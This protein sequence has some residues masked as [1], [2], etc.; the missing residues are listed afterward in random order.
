MSNPNS[1][2]LTKVICGGHEHDVCVTVDR[3]V[4]PELRCPHPSHGSFGGGAGGG[5]VL[6]PDLKDLVARE[7]RENLQKSMRRGYALIRA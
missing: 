1:M 6:P 7:L 2:V 3:G 5:C 4:P